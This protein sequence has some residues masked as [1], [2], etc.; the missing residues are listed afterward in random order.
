MS[1]AFSRLIEPAV[2]RLVT[3][4][5]RN[6]APATIVAATIISIDFYLIRLTTAQIRTMAPATPMTTAIISFGGE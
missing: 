4:Q 6:I 5:I 2:I 1:Q 3:A